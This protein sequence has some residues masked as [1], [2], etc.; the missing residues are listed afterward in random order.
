MIIHLDL[1]QKVLLGLSIRGNT[2][3]GLVAFTLDGND[4]SGTSTDTGFI[5]LVA[6]NGRRDGTSHI[7]SKADGHAFLADTGNVVARLAVRH[8]HVACSLQ[9]FLAGA[10]EKA[11]VVLRTSASGMDHADKHQHNN[12][13]FEDSSSDHHRFFFFASNGK[14]YTVK[15]EKEERRICPLSLFYMRHSERKRVSGD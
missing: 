10:V 12:Q 2:L 1:A 7:S 9:L 8:A 3:A 11:L 15:Q 13:G 14:L 6:A 4:G 5:G